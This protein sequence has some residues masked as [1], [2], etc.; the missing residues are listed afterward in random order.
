MP[1]RRCTRV[2]GGRNSPSRCPSSVW[3]LTWLTLLVD[4]QH[5]RPHGPLGRVTQ[6]DLVR[7]QRPDAQEDQRAILL[8]VRAEPWRCRGGAP[9]HPREGTRRG[10]SR[11][12]RSASDARRDSGRSVHGMR[13]MVCIGYSPFPVACRRRG[14]TGCHRS[15]DHGACMTTR[16]CSLP[17]LPRAAQQTASRGMQHTRSLQKRDGDIYPS[18]LIVRGGIHEAGG[19]GRS[20]LP[21]PCGSPYAHAGMD[22]W[23]SP[24]RAPTRRPPV[25]AAR[26]TPGGAPPYTAPAVT[27][28]PPSARLPEPGPRAP[29]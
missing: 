20:C 28:A 19:A 10:H 25:R 2:S 26:V 3:T 27:G 11:R 29:A 5:R 7:H 24:G 15:S 13:R 9:T 17:L 23:P 1:S 22:H 21:D 18:S 16:P 12:D 4:G 8:L 6:R 14:A